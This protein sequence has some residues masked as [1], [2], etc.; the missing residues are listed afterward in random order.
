MVCQH[1]AGVALIF[2]VSMAV[3]LPYNGGAYMYFFACDPPTLEKTA[4]LS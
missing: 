2:F 4:A 1:I 3:A